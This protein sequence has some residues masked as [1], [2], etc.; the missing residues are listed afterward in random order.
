MDDFFHL[1]MAQMRSLENGRDQLFDANT[2][3][4]AAI[5]AKG[6]VIKRLPPNTRDV[7]SAK[8][9]PMKGHTPWH[10]LGNWPF[11]FL[12]FIVLSIATLNLRKTFK[13]SVKSSKQ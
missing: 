11:W 1:E 3:I 4:T 9:F 7:L 5:D 13:D 6:K 12:S 2:G 8:V 10:Y